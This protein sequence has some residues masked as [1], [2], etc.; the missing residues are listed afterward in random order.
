MKKILITGGSGFLGKNLAINLFDK[1][2]YKIILCSRNIENL[3]KAS[4]D[5]KCDFYPINI[6]SLVSVID[7][8]NNIK[9]DIVIH[10]AATKFVDLSE[11]FPEECIE[12]NI[13]GSI[14]ILR[15]CEMFSVKKLV[16]IST[17]KAAYPDSNIYSQSKSIME[18]YFVNASYKSKI[19]IACIRFGNLCWSTGS[20]FNIWEEM[21]NTK[22]MVF[23]T[24]PNMRRFFIHVNHACFLI[25]TVM[26]N[27]DKCNGL[28]IT[29]YMKSSK[30]LDILKVWSKI[31]DVKWKQIKSRRGDKDDEYLFSQNE[32]KSAGHIVLNKTKLI[33]INKNKNNLKI[34][35][36]ILSSKNSP[37]LS[38]KEIKYLITNKP[39]II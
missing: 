11:K 28:I 16:V 35:K 19:K 10:S 37:K 12:T 26:N 17:D 25:K 3:R 2:K 39:K 14:N 38:V 32:L 13:N 7:A 22:K 1:N 21:T 27:I 15:V 5:T 23:T 36:K 34:F 9:P 4:I 20:V 29:D 18:T 24:G 31:Y 8:F 33:A 30:V 6:N